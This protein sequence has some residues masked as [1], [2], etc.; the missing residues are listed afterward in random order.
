MVNVIKRTKER[1]RRLAAASRR[2][3]RALYLLRQPRGPQAHVH[4]LP[5]EP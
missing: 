5:G 4:L 2:A 1:E 3:A